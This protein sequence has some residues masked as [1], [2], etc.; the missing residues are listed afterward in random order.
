[1]FVV[2]YG[3]ITEK[4]DAIAVNG[5]F[6]YNTSPSFDAAENLAREVANMPTKDVIIVKVFKMEEGENLSTVMVRARDK[7]LNKFQIQ[8]KKSEHIMKRDHDKA[9]CPFQEVD[10][11]KVLKSCT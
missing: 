2:I 7:W 9:L 1:M 3:V 4:D 11:D 6:Y 8:I 10:F 5:P